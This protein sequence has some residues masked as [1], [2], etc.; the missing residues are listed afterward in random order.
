M[1]GVKEEMR[2]EMASMSAAMGGG[3]GGGGA[4]PTAEAVESYMKSKFIDGATKGM[5]MKVK[6]K[7]MKK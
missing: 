7:K 6:S 5:A 4:E 2:R 1:S 3:G